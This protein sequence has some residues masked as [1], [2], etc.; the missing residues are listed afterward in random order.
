MNARLALG[1]RGE[2]IAARAYTRDGFR[3]VD[4]NF[5]CRAGEID[6]VARKGDELVFCEVKTRA[7]DR[8]GLPA[9]AVDARKQA[10]LKRLAAL[11]LARHKVGRVRVRFDVVSIVVRAGTPEVTHFTDAF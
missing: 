1:L 2:A 8:W 11:W 4:R 10:R 9:E 7:S 3:V 6:L 5:R